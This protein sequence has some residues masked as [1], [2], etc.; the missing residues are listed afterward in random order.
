MAIFSRQNGRDRPRDKFLFPVTYSWTGPR[1]GSNQRLSKGNSS[2]SYRQ[3]CEQSVK[4]SDKT[5]T[6]C[7][8]RRLAD[9]RITGK[10]DILGNR[11]YHPITMIQESEVCP[12]CGMGRLKSW[13]ELSLEEQMIAHRLP[14]SASF[15]QQD[16]A[17][18][19]RWCIKCWY[20]ETSGASQLA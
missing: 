12:R 18:R 3:K 13:G 5:L 4:K 10:R 14:Q 16:R 7:P 1:G 15:A 6:F 11:E 9:G 8:R 2:T 19:H 20:E 17:T